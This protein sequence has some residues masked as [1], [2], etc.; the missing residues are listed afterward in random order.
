MT[1]LLVAIAA[2]AA[3]LCAGVSPGH[4]QTYGDAPWCAVVSV[5]TGSVQWDCEYRTVEECV[6]HVL[7]G[8][9]G[10]CNINPYWNGPYP[11]AQVAPGPHPRHSSHWHRSKG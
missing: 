2:P 6:P 3:L 7:T 10:S 4:S 8:N 11:T 5:G 1:R 9:R